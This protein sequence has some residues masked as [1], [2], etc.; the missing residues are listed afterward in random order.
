M[1]FCFLCL[2]LPFGSMVKSEIT[3]TSE[4]VKCK[5]TGVINLCSQC[6]YYTSDL[7]NFKRHLLVHTG[8]KRFKCDFCG[9]CFSQKVH[10]QRHSITHVQNP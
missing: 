6:P 3:E 5:N 10:L 1:H 8:I 9:K 2:G 7:A 4:T